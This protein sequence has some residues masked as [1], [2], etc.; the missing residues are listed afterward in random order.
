M[1]RLSSCRVFEDYSTSTVIAASGHY[2]RGLPLPC[3]LGENRLDPLITGVI[4]PPHTPTHAL[5]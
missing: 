3:E 1:L 4:S 2:Y 5:T